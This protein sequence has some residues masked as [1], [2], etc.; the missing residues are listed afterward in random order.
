VTRAAAKTGAGPIATVA[1]EQHFPESQRIVDD[2]L[3]YSILPLPMRAFVRLTEPAAVRDW[4]VRSLEKPAPGMWG[5]LMSRKRYI[6][7]KLI[8]SSG[9]IDAVVNLGAGFDTRS[10]RLPTLADA[11]VWEVDQAEIIES[12]RARLRKVFGSVPAHV[13]LVPIDFDREDLGTALASHGYSQDN[14]TFFIWEA[15]TQ[16]LTDAGI[17]TTFDF[18]AKA[19]RGS[20]LVFTYIRADFLDGRATYGQEALRKKYV[21]KQKLWLYGMDPDGVAGFLMQYGWRVVEHVGYED[22]ATRYVEPT[23]RELASTPIERIV[24]AEKA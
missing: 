12:K 8:E 15:V 4:M 24:L 16:Y 18:L 10:Y 11:P 21:V 1:V 13:T 7:E 2:S 9:R 17:A 6:D 19:A 20:L 22:L 23:G 5:G 3:A 14:R